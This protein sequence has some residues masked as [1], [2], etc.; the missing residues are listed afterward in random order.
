MPLSSLLD[1]HSWAFLLHSSCHCEKQNVHRCSSLWTVNHPTRAPV[2]EY[3]VLSRESCSSSLWTQGSAGCC[4]WVLK[5]IT[6]LHPAC[7]FC[8]SPTW[9]W[10]AAACSTFHDQARGGR[11][12][13][14]IPYNRGSEERPLSWIAP[15]TQSGTEM[16][17]W[18][19]THTL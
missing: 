2:F 12:V 14:R 8:L 4:V 18:T 9:M 17:T 6:R 5:V 13:T 3:Q 15:V 11:S 1:L 10:Q 7:A 16:W 19:D